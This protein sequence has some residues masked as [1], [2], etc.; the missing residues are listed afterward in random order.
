MHASTANIFLTFLT[1][2]SMF[3]K[4]LGVCLSIENRLFVVCA[5]EKY[6]SDELCIPMFWLHLQSLNS[7]TCSIF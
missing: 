7:I 2:I 4:Y 6:R 5:K 1:R 3:E